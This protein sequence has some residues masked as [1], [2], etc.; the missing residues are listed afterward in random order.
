MFEII[1]VVCPG[2]TYSRTDP[3]LSSSKDK[4]RNVVSCEV[5]CEVQWDLRSVS[6]EWEE[7]S[8][9]EES[10]QGPVDHLAVHSVGGGA[11]VAVVGGEGEP[12]VEGHSQPGTLETLSAQTL[13][14]RLGE[15]ALDVF[16]PGEMP[17]G[18][19][20][21]LGSLLEL[22]EHVLPAQPQHVVHGVP[23]LGEPVELRVVELNGRNS[24]AG[25]GA[26]LG[27]ALQSVR[28]L[29]EV[30]QLVVAAL[31]VPGPVVVNHLAL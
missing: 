4:H 9:V 8:S 19:T 28:L 13:R 1:T 23:V 18:R 12:L 11:E 22:V 7:S 31:P 27:A 3:A 26:G 15:A 30:L 5:R 25:V 17:P 6:P 2:E 24:H 16:P 29:G 14:V 10:P 21:V 20:E